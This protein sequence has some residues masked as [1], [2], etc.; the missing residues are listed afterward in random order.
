MNARRMSLL[1]RLI[2]VSVLSLAWIPAIHAAVSGTESRVALVIGN[3][4]YRDSPLNNPVN[5]ARAVARALTGLGFAVTL[6]EN[7]DQKAMAEAIRDFGERLKR[8][9][10]VGLFYYAGHGVQAGG[11]NFLIPVDAVIKAEDEVAYNSIDANLVLDKMDSAKNRL[12]LMILDACRNNPFAR[13]FRSLSRGLAQMDAPSGTLIAF[14]TAPGMEAADGD[15]QNGLY[16]QHLLR[17]ITTPG[18][19]VEQMFKQVRV[20]VTRD[21]QDKQ[22]PWESSSLKGDFYFNPGDKTSTVQPPSMVAITAPPRNTTPAARTTPGG[23]RDCPTCPEMVTIPAGSFVMGTAEAERGSAEWPT[24]EVRIAK[25][26][27]VGRYEV[28]F[29]EWGQCRVAGVCPKEAHS[30]KRAGQE[31]ATGISWHDAVAFTQW[32]K[33]KTG[34]PYRLLSEAEWEYVA[35]ARTTTARYWGER[36]ESACDFAN[37]LDATAHDG[38]TN[39]AGDYHHCKD[40]YKTV[41]PVGRFTPNAFGIYDILG[42]VA[43]WVEDC[44]NSN[45]AGLRTDGAARLDGD[46]ARH[47]VRGGSWLTG[48]KLVRSAAR[49]GIEATQY[50]P[51]LG[52]RVARDLD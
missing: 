6:K 37:T 48:P 20:G 43:E 8:H 45:L 13:R 33:K 49:H 42:N 4:A 9:G 22:V 1:S 17:H 50:A 40:G 34:K 23:F 32:L 39:L 26:F 10:G 18:M 52:L 15:G 12:N 3:S 11:R 25:A 24:R 47:V 51:A 30:G 14:A 28:T 29:A 35:R 27:A 19:P 36:P 16:T 41:A 38:A 5:D 46:C 21:T 7:Q 31:P 2:G 44:W